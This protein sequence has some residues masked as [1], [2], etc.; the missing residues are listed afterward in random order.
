MLT[1]LHIYILLREVANLSNPSVFRSLPA[2]ARRRED[3]MP[4]WTR[5]AVAVAL[6]GLSAPMAHAWNG[7]GPAGSGRVGARR[8]PDRGA[9]A[10]RDRPV[11]VPQLEKNNLVVWNQT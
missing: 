3:A 7:P 1:I 11:R 8:D 10:R 4:A 2:L 5:L 6:L 9:H